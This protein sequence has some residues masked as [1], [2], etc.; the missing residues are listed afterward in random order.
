MGVAISGGVTRH[1]LALNVATDLA[2]FSRIVPCGDPDKEATSLAREL[3]GR[4]PD[5]RE[6]AEALAQAA[7]SRLGYRSI[8]WLPDVNAL[9]AAP[10]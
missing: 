10:P 4:A 1:G 8:E 2:A 7:V 5:L 9:A 3:Q 6:A